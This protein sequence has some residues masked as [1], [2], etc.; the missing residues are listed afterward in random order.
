MYLF[1]TIL[2]LLAS[3]LMMLIVLSKI[4]KEADWLPVFLQITSIWVCA[5]QPI[6]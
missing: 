5:K 1:L 6:S 4:Q 2:I 3:V